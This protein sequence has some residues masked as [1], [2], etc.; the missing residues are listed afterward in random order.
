MAASVSI[1]EVAPRDGLQ[2]EK[3]FVPTHDKITLVDLLSD[4]GF[5]RIEVTSFVSPKWVPQLAD[6]AAVM[7]GIDRVPGVRYAALT[8]NIKGFEAALAAG[9]DEEH[10]AEEGEGG[11][12]EEGEEAEEPSGFLE[13]VGEAEDAGADD[14]D[15]DVGEGFGL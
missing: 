11:D 3:R 9:A 5:T 13:G 7:A 1:V 8:P 2:N 14:G 15:E 12:E 4:C 10:H 6:A